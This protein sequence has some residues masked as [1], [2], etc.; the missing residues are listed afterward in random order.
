MSLKL[1]APFI[2]KDSNFLDLKIRNLQIQK[3]ETLDSGLINK[4]FKI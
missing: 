2:R 4:L 1:I 3:I